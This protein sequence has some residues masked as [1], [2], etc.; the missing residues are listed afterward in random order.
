[1][2]R[3]LEYQTVCLK[4]YHLLNLGEL[5]SRIYHNW[6]FVHGILIPSRD[7]TINAVLVF[8]IDLYVIELL[9]PEERRCIP[10]GLGMDSS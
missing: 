1:M 5:F 9:Q 10:R 3:K 2:W 6:I 8:L 7:F 4:Q